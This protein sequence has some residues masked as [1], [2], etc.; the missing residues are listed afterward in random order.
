MSGQESDRALI[1]DVTN[2]TQCVI[3]TSSDH[4]YS[5]GDFIRLTDLNSSIP[6]LRGMDPINNHRYKVEKI[7]DTSFY[8]K[9]PITSD[10]IDSTNF[11]PYVEGGRCNIVQDN[12][13]YEG[14]S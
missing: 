11:P 3:T 8:I 13:T 4:G 2:A 10:Y 1:S 6:V 12:F 9:D 7:S 5:S 14:D